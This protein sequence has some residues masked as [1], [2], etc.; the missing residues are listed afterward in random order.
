MNLRQLEYF[1]ELSETE[2]MTQAAQKLN[3]TQPTLSHAIKSLEEKLGVQLFRKKGRNIELTKYGRMFYQTVSNVLLDLEEGV[4]AIKDDISPISGNIDLGF[5]YTMSLEIIP[6][7]VTGFHKDNR[8]KNIRFSF[9]QGNSTELIERLLNEEI[10]LAICSKI[11]DDPRIEYTLFV[12]E[13]IVIITPKD[14]PLAVHDELDLNALKPY[15][16]IGFNDKSGLRPTIDALFMNAGFKP[17]VKYQVEEDQALASL[18]QFNFGVALSPNIPTL[19]VYDVKVIKIKNPSIRRFLY[20]AMLRQNF[21][22]Q[23]VESFCEYL[24]D[25]TDL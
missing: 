9:K 5:T 13:E 21:I 7:M 1:K 23:T 8:F 16:F 6:K 11:S 19:D 12:E 17:D 14:H 25:N 10:D 3:I 4:N 22:S 24:M 20:I 15:P 18:V 2:H